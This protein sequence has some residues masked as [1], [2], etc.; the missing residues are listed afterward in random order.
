MYRSAVILYDKEK[1]ISTINT[2]F[3][4]SEL[5]WIRNPH[6]YRKNCQP[7]RQLIFYFFYL[8]NITQLFFNIKKYVLLT[9]KTTLQNN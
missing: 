2:I 6:I 3:I 8:P 4:W 5:I 9:F 7:Q 1:V